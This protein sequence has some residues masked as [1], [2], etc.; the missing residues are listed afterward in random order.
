M[1]CLG[2]TYEMHGIALS[3]FPIFVVYPERANIQY[4]CIFYRRRPC[5]IEKILS[6]GFE[7]T[8]VYET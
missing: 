7:Y 1:L 4:S 5:L 2:I 8:E 6:S 3:K